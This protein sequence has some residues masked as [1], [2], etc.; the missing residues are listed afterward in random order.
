MTHNARLN[1]D[2]FYVNGK[3]IPASYFQG[4]DTAQSKAVNGDAGGTWAP[5][6][7]IQVGG[8]GIWLGGGLHVVG[9]GA[10]VQTGTGYRILH[11]A[12]DVP[13]LGGGHAFNNRELVT[14]A[15]NG[16][17]TNPSSF[18]LAPYGFGST[19]GGGMVSLTTGARLVVPIRVHDGASFTRAQV[20][21]VVNGGHSVL[22]KVLPALSVIAV[23]SSGTVTTLGFSPW[24]AMSSPGNVGAY[25]GQRLSIVYPVGSGSGG[26]IIDRSQFV[27][28]ALIADESGA[29]AVAG[30]A[31]EQIFC[32][33]QS[34]P[35]CRFQ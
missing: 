34:I 3:P 19:F 33:M 27:Y 22:P 2:T 13:V 14:N 10:T 32:D 7:A 8:A 12:N 26:V 31:Y 18:T 35:D 17:D 16:A 4:I 30:N 21:V 28:Y 25:N 20:N 5:S 23:D 1:P 15:G 24:V 6:S 9:P 29:G 11:A